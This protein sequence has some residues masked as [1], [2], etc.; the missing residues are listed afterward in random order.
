MTTLPSGKSSAFIRLP[1]APPPEDMNNELYLNVQGSKSHLAEHFGRRDSTIIIGEIYISREPTA[2]MA[3]LFVPD[4][5]IAFGVK[6]DLMV[7]RNGYV[8]SEQ[9]KP[10]D[11]VLEV[12]S[13]STGRRDMTVKREGYA[14][15]G[16]PEY[17][18]FDPSG[19]R[20]HDAP[21][22]GERLEQGA[23]VPLAVEQLAEGTWQGY[24][25]ALHLHLRWEEGQL[26]WYDPT[27]D[28]HIPRFQDIRQE[29]EGERQARQAIRQELEGER[30]ARQAA[31]ARLRALEGEPRERP[32]A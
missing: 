15:L 17:W 3:G 2:S 10:P 12:A 30:Q 20:Y 29:L 16:I 8:I 32:E 23:Y 4:L 28:R 18:R 21:L 31:E 9:G 19:G 25:P 22:A 11:F 13:A 5:L 1:D 14:A 7:A 27:T 6:P 24:S 26:G